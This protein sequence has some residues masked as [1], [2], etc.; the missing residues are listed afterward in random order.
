MDYPSKKSFTNKPTLQGLSLSAIKDIFFPRSCIQCSGPVEESPYQ[1]ICKTCSQFLV[2]AHPPNC[3]ICGY[4]F[5]VDKILSKNCPHCAELTPSFSR[6]YTLCLAKKTGRQLIHN[7]KYNNGLYLRK[8]L[9]AI[10]HQ[11]PHLRKICQE[12]ILIPIPLHPTKLRER[13]FNQSHAFA[14]VLQETLNANIQIENALIRTRFT[15]SQTTLSR[16]LRKKNIRKAF[17][18]SPNIKLDLKKKYILVDD[19][20]TTGSTANAC[21]KVLKKAGIRSI[22]L[23]TLGH[24]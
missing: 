20:F 10:I 8:D 23:I 17:A 21:A 18:L 1:Y 12:A 14:Q 24:G 4:P 16:E 11:L 9:E 7:L 6:G 3:K 22:E 15:R 19:V 13:G 2:L 5:L